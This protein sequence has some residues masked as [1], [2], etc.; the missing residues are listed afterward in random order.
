M[1]FSFYEKLFQG[2]SIPKY[3]GIMGLIIII[4]FLLLNIIGVR[5]IQDD[6]YTSFRYA[7]NFVEG[8]G[9]V[10]NA[11]E[12]VE[13]YTNFLW[14][15]ILSLIYFL[16][17]ARII[18][19]DLESEAQFLSITFSVC[20]LILTYLL[21]R[22][23]LNREDHERSTTANFVN[24]L[25]I[26]IP[27]FLLSVST[28]L[29]YW[30]VSA[31]ETSLF[32]FL[33]LLLILIYLRKKET[34]KPNFW[35]IS[36]SV[37][38]SL[39]RPEGLIVFALILSH[40]IFYNMFLSEEKKFLLRIRSVVD[41]TLI[42]EISFFS[43]PLLIYFCF[44]LIYYGYPLPNTFYSKTEFSFEFIVRGLNYFFDFA[45]AYLLYGFVLLYPLVLFFDKKNIREFSLLLWLT[46]AWTILNILIGGDVLP[47][48]RF[49]LPLMPLMFILFMKAIQFTISKFTGKK[50]WV[51]DLIS[52]ALIMI[53]VIAGSVN[54][55]IQK[56]QMMEKHSY[57]SGLVKKMKV[58]ASWVNTQGERKGRQVSVAMST[59]GAFSFYSDAR[60]IDLVGLTDEYISHH[61]KEVEG[62]DE[63]L[64]VLWK[65]RHYNAEYI[66]SQEPDYIIFPAGAKPSAFAECA[67]YVQSEFRKN[68]YTQLFYSDQLHQ[69]IP[70]FTRKEN[71]GTD[72]PKLNC[73]NK[74]LKHYIEANNYFLEMIQNN[75]K[76]TLQKILAECD[77]VEYFC[78]QKMSDV[79]TL[80]GMAFYHAG[81]LQI[82]Q[83]YLVKAVDEEDANCIARY[84][85]M[86]IYG[87]QKKER[88]AAKL[89][90]EIVRYSPDAF[91][92][93]VK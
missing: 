36:I 70:V 52:A 17:H 32:V 81:N 54:Y 57:E 82:A 14:V 46:F 85:L 87:F 30:G 3:F 65:E 92:N 34:D 91:P 93:L 18:S 45:K 90:D 80:K 68:Y 75:D 69:M 16:N 28:P 29:I 38:N 86:K 26:L 35:W 21:S 6:A 78:P 60:V 41:K 20:T 76:N 15:M 56:S 23:I 22:T 25:I 59:I 58:Y 55:S 43:F 88:E 62:I 48:H 27:V 31:M 89:I 44:R 73:G 10:F 64:P 40:K 13:G 51:A 47:I 33:T 12:R 77:S 66:I 74:Y 5:F 50:K 71:V 49:F 37:F 53:I 84:Y 4:L 11:G 7:K 8:K 63:D 61:P 42:Q 83:S 1:K 67:L 2:N 72:L 79:N 24:E 19:L 39:L 9:L